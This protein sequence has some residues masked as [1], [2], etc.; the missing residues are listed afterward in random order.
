MGK[1]NCNDCG[2]DFSEGYYSGWDEAED[3]SL[4]LCI[5]C[6]RKRGDPGHA[7]YDPHIL[8]AIGEDPEILALGDK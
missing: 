6:A 2:G 3:R 7:H 5:P 4:V 1:G 8:D